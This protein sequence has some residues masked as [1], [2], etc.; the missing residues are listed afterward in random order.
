MAGQ[1][2]RPRIS[3]VILF[4]RLGGHMIAHHL[5][6]SCTMVL[7]PR[8]GISPGGPSEQFQQIIMS[9]SCSDL[10]RFRCA[11]GKHQTSLFPLILLVVPLYYSISLFLRGQ[12][13]IIFTSWLHSYQY[14]DASSELCQSD[15]GGLIS[16]E[17]N[18]PGAV[19]SA[20]GAFNHLIILPR[21]P[22]AGRSAQLLG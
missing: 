21:A 10:G 1:Q 8:W 5:Y 19:S 11:L 9:Q 2:H 13:L 17:P 7:S 18:A 3:N 4:A 15:L 16:S 14:S 12:N 22:F 20:R 6:L